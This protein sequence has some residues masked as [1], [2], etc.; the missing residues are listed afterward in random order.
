MAQVTFIRKHFELVVL[1]II[2]ISVL[3]MVIEFL[4]HRAQAKREAE[5]TVGTGAVNE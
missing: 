2:A 3:P 5:A 1:I 4:R